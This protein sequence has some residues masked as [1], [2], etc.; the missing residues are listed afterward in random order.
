RTYENRYYRK[1]G[2][3][4]VMFWEGEW[5]SD[6]QLLYCTGRDITEQ[7]RMEEVEKAY[8]KELQHVSEHLE[9]IT[10]G[11]VGLDEDAR[12]TYW[13]KAAEAIYKLPREEVL[14]KVLW[15]LMVEPAKSDFLQRY[16]EMKEKGVPV[17]FELYSI[18]SECWLEFTSYM[19]E[20]GMSVY[21]RDIT[22]MRQM[23]EKLRAQKEIQQQRTTAAVIKAA[24]EERAI[25][26]REL[27]DNVNQVLT[28]VK[29]YTELCMSDIDIKD[30][31]LKKSALLIQE[32]IDEIRGLSKRLSAPSLGN[33]RL[34]ESVK[35][36]TDAINTTRRIQVTYENDVEE[37]DVSEDLHVG[38][39]RILQ[40][41]FTNILKHSKA[42]AACLKITVEENTFH[43][44]LQDNGQGFD[45]SKLR[46]GIGLDNMNS[47]AE[48]LN[49][50]L[51][52]T[53]SPGNGCLLELTLPLQ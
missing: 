33:I 3:I 30:E 27:H 36:L 43:L 51:S 20:S 17:T 47:R 21:F 23:H 19:S 14:G 10:D 34:A 45:P 11:F 25:V 26:G 52:L 22:L 28:T 4:A 46:R 18:R 31:L 41:Q 35:E 8:H 32:S 29:L 44:S 42:T 15:D 7:R 1:N 16:Q 39:Y 37:L 5:N 24:E 50:K 40:E 6:D 12:I 48:V 53:S 49:G 9:R 38:V 13:N 2:D